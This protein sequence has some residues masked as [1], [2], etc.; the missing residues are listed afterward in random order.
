MKLHNG[1]AILFLQHM[2]GFRESMVGRTHGFA[3]S[4]DAQA[5]VR[6]SALLTTGPLACSA[7]RSPVCAFSVQVAGMEGLTRK[8]GPS[9][10]RVADDSLRIHVSANVSGP[11]HLRSYGARSLGT[12]FR[13]SSLHPN[14]N[15]VAQ[16]IV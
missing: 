12:G 11:V 13:M 3:G 14:R 7:V 1:N 5:L 6:S 2:D 4:C 16:G 9:F 15:C 8:C 10:L